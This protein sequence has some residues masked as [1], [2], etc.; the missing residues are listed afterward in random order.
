MNHLLNLSIDLIIPYA[1]SSIIHTQTHTYTD[2]HLYSTLLIWF[3][4]IQRNTEH[5]PEKGMDYITVLI[6]TL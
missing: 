4:R 3:T 2:M 1:L 6:V 5:C